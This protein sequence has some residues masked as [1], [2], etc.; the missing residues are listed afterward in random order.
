MIISG[1]VLLILILLFVPMFSA[2]KVVEVSDTVMVTVQKQIPVTVTED[3]RTKVY[4]GY[5]QE[6]GQTYGGYM[7]PIMVIGQQPMDAGEQPS[8]N[9][10][11]SADRGPVYSP[12]YNNYGVPGRRYQIDASDEIVD[13]QQANGPDGSLTITLTNVDGKSTVYRYIDQYDLTKTG[14]IKIPTTVTKMNTVSEQEPRQVIKQQVVHIRVNL[15]QLLLADATQEQGKAWG[16]MTSGTKNE[17]SA[18]WGSSSSDIFVSGVSGTLLHYDGRAW[19]AM[20]SGT[21]N[22]LTSLWGQSSSD[23]FAV[24]L[25]G[26]VLHY[27]GKA[28]GIMTSGTTDDLWQIWGQ[29]SSDVFVAG[30]NGTI[31]HYDGKG[32]AVM[33]SGTKYHLA[34]VW[35][36]SSYDVFAVGNNGTVLY[37]NGKA[38]GAMTSGTTNSLSCVWGRSSSDVFAVGSNGTILHYDGKGWAVMTSGTTNDLDCVW[39]NSAS[40]VFATGE[41]GTILHYDGKSWDAMTSGTT[42]Y[43][44]Y[45]WGSSASDV[46]VVGMAGTILHYPTAVAVAPGNTSQQQRA[47]VVQFLK[48][49]NDAFSNLTDTMK[50]PDISSDLGSGDASRMLSAINTINQ[51]IDTAQRQISALTPPADI[52]ELAEMKDAVLK[53]AS[54]LGSLFQQ[55]G[56][57]IQN[58]D[59]AQVREVLTK[60]E[61]LSSDPD[62]RKVDEIEKSLLV[63]YKIANSEVGYSSETW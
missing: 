49:M 16:A 61:Q 10:G 56:M 36:S 46:F 57:A 30:S 23:V 1:A 12:I 38:W 11:A 8:G 2:T 6:Q 20:T 9:Y 50:S 51:Q 4:V 28:W 63:K 34:G 13:F 62:I 54:T 44:T 41:N 37:Y 32:W 24:G 25:N 40:N 33:T 47:R 42:N 58:R 26:T 27:S 60:M 29:S 52:P 21:T 15:I 18:I 43:L 53:S 17:L 22:I 48:Q 45:V 39:G 59:A 19:G 31:L 3:V 55:F 7:G 14:E 5:M 35:G